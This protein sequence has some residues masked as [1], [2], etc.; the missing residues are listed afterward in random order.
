[1]QVCVLPWMS[2]T[3]QVTFVFPIGNAAGALFDTESTPQLSAVEGVPNE[4]PVAV[5]PEFVVA[6]TAVGQVM[7]G[8]SLSVTVTVMEQRAVSWR[9]ST[10]IQFTVVA[11]TG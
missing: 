1:M 4:T 3:V 7:V 11:P 2:V 5:Q 10:A 9:S 6:L 8:F